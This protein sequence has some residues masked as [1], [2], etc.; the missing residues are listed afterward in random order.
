[1]VRP[2]R[3]KEGA[4]CAAVDVYERSGENCEGIT[5]NTEPVNATTT[6]EDIN[7]HEQMVRP[8]LRLQR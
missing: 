2:P 1:M 5:L 8:I 4:C 7:D 3:Y 6:D